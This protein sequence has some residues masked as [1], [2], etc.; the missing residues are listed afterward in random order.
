MNHETCYADDIGVLNEASRGARA[1]SLLGVALRHRRCV[2][3]HRRDEGA[4][5]D[6]ELLFC[7][8]PLDYRDNGIGQYGIVGANEGIA[9]FSRKMRAASKP[10]RLLP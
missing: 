10:V 8:R 9:V 6:V 3:F 5:N 4:E 2:G 7:S 1:G